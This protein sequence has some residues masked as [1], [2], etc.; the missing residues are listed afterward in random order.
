MIINVTHR[1]SLL[2]LS[3]QVYGSINE[4]LVLAVA[5]GISVT[6]VLE[7]NT[8]IEVPD[9]EVSDPTTQA[10]YARRNLRPATALDTQSLMD[11]TPCGIGEM[12]IGTNFIVG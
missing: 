3:I 2:D 4:V 11:T 1:Q 12:I 6:D 9:I 7:P 10:Y 8:K 5:N